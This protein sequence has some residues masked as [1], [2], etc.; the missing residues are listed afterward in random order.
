[1]APLLLVLDLVHGLSQGL[2]LAQAM[3][4]NIRKAHLDQAVLLV[5]LP[6]AAAVVSKKED[7]MV[8]LW[9]SLLELAS[10]SS[11]G[12]LSEDDDLTLEAGR[13]EVEAE[14]GSSLNIL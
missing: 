3:M 11:P 6:G 12:D 9:Q 10:R 8:V 4:A 14:D 2:V 13:D 1:M 7:L 5:L